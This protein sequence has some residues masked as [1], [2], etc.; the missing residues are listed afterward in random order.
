M[1]TPVHLRDLLVE[2]GTHPRG[3]GHLSSASG[4]V[5][6]GGW[7]YVVADDEHHLGR[8]EATPAPGGWVQL[9]R[10]RAGDLPLDKARRKKLKP[11]LETLVLLPATA[12]DPH[13]LLLA[14]G[15]G[16]RPSREQGFMIALDSHGALAAAPR[17]VELATL[18]QP[19]RSTFPDLNIEGALVAGERFH[20]LQRGNR[21]DPRNACIEYPLAQ[22]QDWLSGRRSTPPAALRIVQ[23]SLGAVAGVPLGFTDGAGLPGGGWIFSAVAEDTGDSYH[24]GTCAGSALGWVD[25]DGQLQRL[26]PL[27]GAPKVEGI[28]LA[29]DGCLMVTDSDD[30]GVP[31]RLLVLNHLSA[32]G[33]P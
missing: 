1:L 30:P 23:F 2:P 13:G 33:P 32:A 15:S 22:M 8:F 21:G 25:A 5:Q 24:D 3:Q 4:L 12:G 26:K 29:G 19:L 31:S 17:V 16:S 14:L 11:D 18:F 7:L 6:A 20:L 28:A 9:H 10:M 27:A